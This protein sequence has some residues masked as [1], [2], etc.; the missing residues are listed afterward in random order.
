MAMRVSF[1]SGLMRNDMHLIVMCRPIA[2]FSIP[3]M[4]NGRLFSLPSH[5][6]HTILIQSLSVCFA[7]ICMCAAYFRRPEIISIIIVV[8]AQELWEPNK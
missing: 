6:H 2:H 8:V 1:C 5:N 3:A 7:S 4:A